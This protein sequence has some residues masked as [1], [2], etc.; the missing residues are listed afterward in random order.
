MFFGCIFCVYS[1]KFTFCLVIGSPPPILAIYGNLFLWFIEYPWLKIVKSLN[2]T[3]VGVTYFFLVRIWFL[4]LP[5]PLTVASTEVLFLYNLDRR[6][7]SARI[8]EYL[9]SLLVR[10]FD[11]TMLLYFSL[12]FWMSYCSGTY[13]PVSQSY[14]FLSMKVE[15][16]PY[17]IDDNYWVIALFY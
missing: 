17:N 8:L 5:P 4:L 2:I 16:V 10:S 13:L 6:L 3:L 11:Y 9:G 15:I 1:I 12:A 7:V 14:L